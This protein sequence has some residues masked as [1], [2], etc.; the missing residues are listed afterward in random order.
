MYRHYFIEQLQPGKRPVG[1]G[2]QLVEQAELLGGQG[3]H[4]VPAADGV[5]IVIQHDVPYCNLPFVHNAGA[6]QKRPDPQ[7]H[8][9]FVNRLGDVIV[10]TNQ[11]A[12]VLIFRQGLGRDHQD[13]QHAARFPD[14]LGQAEPVKPGHHHITDQQVNFILVH[15]LQGVLA[16]RCG[17]GFIACAAQNGTEQP[18]CAGVVF[19]HQ[20]LEHRGPPSRAQRLLLLYH[21][22]GVC[23]CLAEKFSA[24]LLSIARQGQ[25]T[26][27]AGAL[28]HMNCTP[29]VRQYDILNNKWGDFY[30]KRSTK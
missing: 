24:V 15:L 17:H 1:V 9:L 25:Q 23:A 14:R 7:Q 19:R 26:V 4:L 8:F 18:V 2:Q 29:F 22:R 28:L 13:R 16:I 21:S 12:A 11:E 30:A 6:A 3:L 27:N 10:G 5:G 20:N